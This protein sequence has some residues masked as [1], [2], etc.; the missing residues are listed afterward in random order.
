[1]SAE[2]VAEVILFVT[3]LADHI[4]L[5]SVDFESAAKFRG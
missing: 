4:Q 1:M 2:D 5:H 3:R